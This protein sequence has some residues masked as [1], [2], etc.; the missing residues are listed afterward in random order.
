MK[1]VFAVM[2]VKNE[3]DIIGYN[4]DWLQTQ[5]ITH[6]FIANN[7]ST[8]NTLNILIDKSEK[9]GNITIFQDN[10]FAYEQAIKMNWWIQKCYEMGAEI[11]VPIDADEIWYS[12]V[13]N[14]TLS[15]TLTEHCF[16]DCIFEADAI[17]FIPTI[18]DK[19]E[20]NPFESIVNVKVDSN[21]FKSVAFTKHLNAIIT[22]GNH[23]VLN[24]PGRIIKNLIGIKHYQ[25]RNFDQFV[26]K[27]RNGKT[28]ME[29]TKMPDY[30]CSH[31][32]IKGGMTDEELKN[33]WNKYILQPVKKYEGL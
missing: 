11:I 6:F 5:G 1:K 23:D 21:S 32:R 18:N 20:P 30:M 31:W 17:D 19:N 25:Y 33:W 14:K 16:G 13:V 27:M 7:L 15:E 22:M 26:K 9:Y 2:M 29:S 28:V 3:E 12:K 24:H 4:I 10:E 8:D